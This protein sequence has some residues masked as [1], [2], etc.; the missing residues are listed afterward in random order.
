MSLVSCRKFQKETLSVA[1][2]TAPPNA[3]LAQRRP[4][5]IIKTS[6]EACTTSLLISTTPVHVHIFRTAPSFAAAMSGKASQ[7]QA[8]ASLTASVPF[9]VRWQSGKLTQA[10][11]DQITVYVDCPAK[12]VDAVTDG[13]VLHA[14]AQLQDQV[15]TFIE[16]REGVKLARKSAEV[17]HSL[18]IDAC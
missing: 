13:K 4:S 3:E 9:K 17:S 12:Q 11:T 2:N 15:L 14:K 6:I 7:R 8:Q 10:K 18:V 5:V 1:L 16:N